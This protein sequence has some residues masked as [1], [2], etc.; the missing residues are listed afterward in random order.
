M[1]SDFIKP[2]L[3]GAEL[4]AEILSE[5]VSAVFVYPGGTIAPT[6]N[7][8]ENAGM[9]IY[10]ART[11]QGAGFASIGLARS[12]EF[13]QV[14][15]V[16]SGPGVTNLI[17]PIADAFYDS[18]P[19]VAF[20]GQV[21]QKDSKGLLPIRQRGFQETDNEQLLKSVS[22]LVLSPKNSKELKRD[23]HKAFEVANS[24]RQ[25]PVVINLHM[26]V[27]RATWD[28]QE[29][30]E[31]HNSHQRMHDTLESTGWYLEKIASQLRAA[32]RPIIV[33][34]RGALDLSSVE[35]IRLFSENHYIPI[36][37]SLHALGISP[38][39]SDLNLKFHGHTGERIA[40]HLIQK[41]DFVLVLGS[42][43]DVRQTGTRY[44]E[45][46]PDA[47]RIRVD[48]DSDE[49]VNSRISMSTNVVAEVKDWI[50]AFCEKIEDNLSWEKTQWGE[51]I[52]QAKALEVLKYD[53]RRNTEGQEGVN[54]YLV[55]S[56]LNKVILKHEVNIVT[57]VGSH[58]QWAARELDFE[59]PRTSWFTSGGLGTMGFDLPVSIGAALADKSRITVCLVGDGSFQM[60]IQELA[61]LRELDLPV[62]ILVFDNSKLGIV[63]QFQKLNWSSDP[64]CGA[65]VNPNFAE[66]SK[67]YSIPAKSVSAKEEIQPALLWLFS[68][69]GPALLNV[70]TAA[71]IDVLPLLLANDTLDQMWPYEAKNK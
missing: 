71:D 32:E 40:G 68:Q 21:G 45:F 58:Q 5:Y 51:S 36:S 65:K 24:G 54:P 22:K 70:K 39:N 67:A 31:S 18:T 52:R 57:G 47:V 6:L 20:C 60:N 44:E 34:G 2:E 48:L 28:N 41:S 25:G 29:I 4:I 17:T 1:E 26:D 46:A 12:L 64:T 30:I 10:T 9:A 62:K 23:I 16:S 33:V 8:L 53:E 14:V 11:E 56:E 15:L 61:F 59:I 7:A 35:T 37:H 66:I 43:L 3:T 19:L 27:Q 69:K 42:R 63:S 13:S 49:L 38:S 50:A 55:L